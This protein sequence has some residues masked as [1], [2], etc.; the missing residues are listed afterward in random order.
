MK[1]SPKNF[2]T[3][4]I[5][6]D[7]N[8]ATY[9]FMVIDSKNNLVEV[10][11]IMETKNVDF[12]KNIFPLKCSGREQIQRTLRD[13]SNESFEFEPRRSKRDRKKQTLEVISTPS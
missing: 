1:L 7:E 2:D 5:G 12:L 6:Y 3:V 9:R 8:S 4:F 13:E 10:N 11:T